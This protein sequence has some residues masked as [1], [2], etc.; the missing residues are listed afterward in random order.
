MAL[1]LT[2][3]VMFWLIT[4][5]APWLKSMPDGE[6]PKA[7]AAVVLAFGVYGTIS[8]ALWH[9]FR[10]SRWLRRWLLSSAYVEG[11]WVGHYQRHG[12]DRY[13]VEYIDQSEGE[14]RIF[15]RE[16]D[17]NGKTRGSWHSE[18]AMLD[19][20]RRKLV[21]TYSCDMHARRSGHRGVGVFMLCYEGKG[22]PS[23]L[24]GYA[25][26]LLDGDKD[27]NKEYRVSFKDIPDEDALKEARA[28]FSSQ[29]FSPVLRASV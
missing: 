11:T 10:S 7:V 13:T 15:G 21:Y 16:F 20:T 26:D 14:V 25:A 18:T 2:V 5:V 17:E 24:D 28:R 3:F 29:T 12:L 19:L 22:A 8:K 27:P 9:V 6:W 1:S 4:I 23:I